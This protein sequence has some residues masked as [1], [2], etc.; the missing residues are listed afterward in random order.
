MLCKL[1]KLQDLFLSVD[2]P[3]L[4]GSF[5]IQRVAIGH[6]PARWNGVVGSVRPCSAHQWANCNELN[7]NTYLCYGH[8]G[9]PESC[10]QRGPLKYTSGTRR[11]NTPASKVTK[12]PAVLAIV[13]MVSFH[14]VT[15]V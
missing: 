2:P 13:P 14:Q 4:T 12:R 3:R 1:P 10:V 7:K 8:N 9:T 11:C 5:A 15:V 6:F